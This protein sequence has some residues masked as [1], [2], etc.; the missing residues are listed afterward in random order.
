MTKQ[1]NNNN[2]WGMEM[3]VLSEGS[4]MFHGLEVGKCESHSENWGNTDFL[5]Q[6]A[7]ALY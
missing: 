1:L 3:N 5:E 4:V 6:G 7:Q 2:R